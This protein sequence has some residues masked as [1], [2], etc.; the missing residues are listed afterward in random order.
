[1]WVVELF[2]VKLTSY[3]AETFVVQTLTKNVAMAFA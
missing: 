1:V 2:V 3:V